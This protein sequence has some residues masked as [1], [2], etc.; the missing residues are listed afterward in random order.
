MLFLVRAEEHDSEFSFE[1]TFTTSGRGTGRA[2]SRY[3]RMQINSDA[4]SFVFPVMMDHAGLLCVG[5][6]LAQPRIPVAGTYL[7]PRRVFE[8]LGLCI[9]FPASFDALSA[10]MASPF[11]FFSHPRSSPSLFSW[12][13]YICFSSP[14][15]APSLISW[16]LRL[17]LLPPLFFPFPFP[18]PRYN[19]PLWPR[20][21]WAAL[22]S[23][24]VSEAMRGCK[25]NGSPTAQASVPEMLG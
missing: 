16:P 7:P 11:L 25:S 12:P 3:K 23:G 15:R 22:L 18:D 8:S 10:F 19:A 4:A 1:I 6:L 2:S 5:I 20:V 9:F 13:L 24:R 17:C 14:V 21:P